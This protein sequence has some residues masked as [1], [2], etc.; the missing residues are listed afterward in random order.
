LKQ[1]DGDDVGSEDVQQW[2]A[3]GSVRSAERRSASMRRLAQNADILLAVDV[4]LT[5]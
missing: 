2:V 4:D 3:I 1:T 5:S